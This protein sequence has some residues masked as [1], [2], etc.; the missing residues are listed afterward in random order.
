MHLDVK[1]TGWLSGLN[2]LVTRKLLKFL[3]LLNEMSG[4]REN[5]C[6][7]PG[8]LRRIFEVFEND[9]FHCKVL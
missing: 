9:I 4:D 3:S 6:L 8:S 1:A 2:A 5:M 7:I